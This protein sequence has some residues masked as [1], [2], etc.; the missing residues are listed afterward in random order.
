M[1]KIAWTKCAPF[2]HSISLYW[3][4][5][6]LVLELRSNVLVSV[7]YVQ[8]NTVIKLSKNGIKSMLRSKLV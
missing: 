2:Q 6:Y 3:Y 5:V 1:L 7:Y 8:F 4:N